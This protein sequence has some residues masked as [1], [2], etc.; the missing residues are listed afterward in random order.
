[1]TTTDWISIMMAII[2]II[3]SLIAYWVFRASTDPNVIVYADP[4]R[5][6][7][8]IVNLVIK[9]I[10]SGAALDIDFSSDR[11]LPKN[12]FSIE[13]PKEMPETM[14]NGPL[15]VGVPFLAPQQEL[16]LTWGQ[17]GGLKKYLGNSSITITARYSRSSFLFKKLQRI[18]SMSKVDITSFAMV[19]ISDHNWSEKIAKNLEQTNKRLSSIESTLSKLIKSN[20]N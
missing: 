4:D 10:G 2:A 9:N 5:K 18:E 6:R 17:Y 16:I 19:D 20:N 8:S 13:T 11:P 7:P 1:M 15:I 14:N 3:S 12:A